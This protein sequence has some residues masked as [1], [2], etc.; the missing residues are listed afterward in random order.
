MTTATI[1]VTDRWS[2]NQ[3]A[4]REKLHASTIWRW[5]LSGVRGTKLRAI[6]VGG[7][8]FITE[9]DWQDF[10]LRYRYIETTYHITVRQTPE[11]G[12]TVSV[13]GTV[14]SE[15]SISLRNDRGDHHVEV[16][17]PDQK[18]ILPAPNKPMS[19]MTIK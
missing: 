18:C 5:M 19:P 15:P 14:Q 3:L 16:C 4:R 11:A 2:V 13:D 9:A 10:K 17:L 7:R 8:R 12:M 6:R 1:S